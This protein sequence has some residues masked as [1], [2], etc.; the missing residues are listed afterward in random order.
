MNILFEE[1]VEAL[2]DVRFLTTEETE[3]VLQTFIASFP[4][5]T[6]GCGRLNWKD[7]NHK[8]ALNNVSDLINDN[9]VDLSASCYIIW[10]DESFPILESKLENVINAFDDVSAV[11]FD[12]W[13]YIPES[14][15]VIESLSDSLMMTRN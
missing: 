13:V 8:M 10:N 6:S 1:A 12:T 11:S 5:E 4:F 14:T 7:I 2:K 9:T 15:N 3:R